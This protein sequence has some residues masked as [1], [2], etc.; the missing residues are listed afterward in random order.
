VNEKDTEDYII[1]HSIQ[2]IVEGKAQEAPYSIS[3]EEL[4]PYGLGLALFFRFLKHLTIVMFIC[5]LISIPAWYS[6]ISGGGISLTGSQSSILTSLTVAN[7]P[8]LT[9]TIASNTSDTVL[10]AEVLTKNNAAVSSYVS[11]MQTQLY[12][13]S[14]PDAVYTFVFVVFLIWWKRDIG[15][16]KNKVKQDV[17]VENYT[18]KVEGFPEL[19]VKERSKVSEQVLKNIFNNFCTDNVDVE[20]ALVR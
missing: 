19:P 20:V 3:Y 6:N 8:S 17:T 11:N 9:L 10:V 14:I 16:I 15:K 5:A 12:L 18:I 7:Q 13:V 2:L 4:L 1:N